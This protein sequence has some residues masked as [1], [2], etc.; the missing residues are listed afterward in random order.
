MSNDF[1]KNVTELVI[2]ILQYYT[3]TYLNV[4]DIIKILRINKYC[5]RCSN[6]LVL[7]LTIVELMIDHNFI[8]KRH[9]FFRLSI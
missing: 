7:F 3:H 5:L 8:G 2:I 4:Y 6:D 1:K 9:I